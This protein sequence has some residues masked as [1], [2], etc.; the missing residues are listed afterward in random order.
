MQ[1]NIFDGSKA[2]R[3]TIG[4]TSIAAVW[5]AALYGY[6]HCQNNQAVPPLVGPLLITTAI[7]CTGWGIVFAKAA[8]RIGRD[9]SIA[10]YLCKFCKFVR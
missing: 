1:T 3:Y 4:V 10:F 8:E 5:G 6:Q 9:L 7:A 2:V